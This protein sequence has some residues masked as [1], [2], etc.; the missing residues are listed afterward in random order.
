MGLAWSHCVNTRFIVS[1]PKRASSYHVNDT[2]GDA[3]SPPT[4]ENKENE[5]NTTEGVL[6]KRKLS[7]VFVNSG[8][9]KGMIDVNMKAQRRYLTLDFSSAQQS[10]RVPFEIKVQGIL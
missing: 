6:Q 4:E 5:L 3:D 7:E 9:E 2:D 8:G 1:K 10:T